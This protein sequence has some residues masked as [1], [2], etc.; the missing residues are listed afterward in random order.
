MSEK[1]VFSK[2]VIIAVIAVLVVLVACIIIG[3]NLN[4][5]ATNN[6]TVNV[7]ENDEYRDFE[8][9]TEEQ[10]NNGKLNICLVTKTYGSSYWDVL[11]QGCIDAAADMDVNLYIAGVAKESNTDR[12]AE[13][14]EHALLMEPDAIIVS[15]ADTS[16]IIDVVKRINEKEIPLIFVDTILNGQQFDVCFMT[17][18]MQAG[19][20]VAIDMVDKLRDLGYT[21]EDKLSVGIDI[22]SKQSQ[23][24]IERLAGFNE[25]WSS[26][27]PDNWRVLD[28]IKCNDGSA[29]VAYE[30]CLEFI[31]KNADLAGLIGLNNGSTVGLSRGLVERERKDIALVGFD[32]SNEIAALIEG[33]EYNVST[34]VQLQYNMGYG[35][36]TESINICSG[37]TPKYKFYNTGISKVNH[38]NYNNPYIVVNALRK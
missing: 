35:A 36:V 22:G 12:L 30:Q 29:D 8:P 9:P 15:P 23:T 24:I 20:M 14:M 34:M 33:G 2:K 1:K 11:I 31:D 13:L 37:M 28:T 19:R 7:A 6:T 4:N 38:D 18:N 5:R 17:D 25:Y 21:P 27:A 16:K 10:L 32:Y 26:N 3:F